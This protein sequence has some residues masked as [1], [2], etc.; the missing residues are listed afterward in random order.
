[1]MI[2]ENVLQAIGCTPLIKLNRIN[3]GLSGTICVKHEA[4]NPGGSVKDRIA[5]HMVN[6]AEK[7]GKLRPGGTIIECTSGNTG[8]GLAITA[9]VRGYQAIFTMPDKVS[10]EKSKLLKAFGAEVILTPTAVGP[11]DPKSYYSVARRLSEEIENSFFPNQ[12]DNAANPETHYLTT[13]PEIWEATDGEIT[14][15]VAGMGTGGTISGIGKYLKEKNPNVRIV[16]ADPVGSLYTHFFHTGEMGEAHT[17]K[18]EGIGED[19]MPST[20][21]FSL[22]DEVHQ[23]SDIDSFRMA[24]RL[25]KEEAIFSGSSAGCAMVGALRA[26]ESMKDGDLM[27]VIIPDTGERYLSKC[28]DEDWLMRNQLLD[29][30][31]EMNVGAILSRKKRSSDGLISVAPDTRLKD[32]IEMLREHDISQIPVEENGEIVGS[33][34]ETSVLGNLLGGDR[35]LEGP[36]R[37]VMEEP[38]PVVGEH[39]PTHE[40]VAHF[41][42]G[43]PAVMVHFADGTRQ[44]VT[45]WDVLHSVSLKRQ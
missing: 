32:A 34:R 8:L 42:H 18:T 21:D 26:A 16:G 13:G 2:L 17:Y 1:M 38:F 23:V 39:T 31:I 19:I 40:I 43:V 33:I 25:V 41:S 37:D 6:V 28:Y 14:H 44:I 10:A 27:V 4:S 45:K 9:A 36:V 35:V 15:F 22:I 11:D 3:A 12:Y 20:I 7:E 29:S 5:L 24:R 30:P